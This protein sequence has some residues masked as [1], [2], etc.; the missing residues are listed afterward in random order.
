MLLNENFF[1]IKLF[2]FYVVELNFVKPQKFSE[3][4]VGFVNF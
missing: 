3:W 2:R 1:G 4:F